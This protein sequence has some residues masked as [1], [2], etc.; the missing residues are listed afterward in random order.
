[1]GNC[2]AKQESSEGAYTTTK[3][4]LTS[5]EQSQLPLYR[6]YRARRFRE[7]LEG[8]GSQNRSNFRLQ[9]NVEVEVI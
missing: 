1:M 3:C 7:S 9:R 8:K 6:S 5:I 4:R 2:K